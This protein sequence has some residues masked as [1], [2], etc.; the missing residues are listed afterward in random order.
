[1]ACAALGVTPAAQLIAAAALGTAAGIP[2][3]RHASA[4]QPS[5]DRGAKVRQWLRGWLD[6]RLLL[7]G[8]VMLGVGLGEGAANNWLTL[9]VR[10]DHGQGAAVAAL[11]FAAVAAAGS[12][13]P[14]LTAPAP[15][16]ASG[17]GT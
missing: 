5:P 12:L 10:N 14:R 1:V 17:P 3:G 4:G 7:I 16:G 2:P 13:R 9:A 15:A 6:W 8:V 11:S